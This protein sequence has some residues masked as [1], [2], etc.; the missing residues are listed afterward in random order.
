MGLEEYV[1]P[2]FTIECG[3]CCARESSFQTDLDDAVKDFELGGWKVQETDTEISAVCRQCI[4][5]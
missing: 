2:T 3:N 4:E 1:E 5:I